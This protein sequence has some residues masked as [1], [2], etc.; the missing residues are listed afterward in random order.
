MF[1]E[2]CLKEHG[3]ADPFRRP[4]HQSQPQ[5]QEVFHQEAA[6]KEQTI[7]DR[8]PSRLIN[9][10]AFG[11]DCLDARLVDIPANAKRDGD[12]GPYASLSY[13]WGPDSKN[14]YKTTLENLDSRKERIIWSELPK[15]F[16][17]AFH[18][19]RESGFSALDRRH[20]HRSEFKG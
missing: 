20:L 13:C 19:T 16:Q 8:L 14:V 7:L 11:K 4:R 17:D 3:C 18:I 6:L 1:M 2:M 9:L 10:D 12:Q 15:T 5:A